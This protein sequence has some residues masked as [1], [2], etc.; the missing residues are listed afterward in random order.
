MNVQFH[1]RNGHA[2]ATVALNDL[3]QSGT[4]D[5]RAAVCFITLPGAVFLRRHAARLSQNDGFFVASIDPP[6]NLDAML[7]LHRAAPGRIYIH[8]GGTTPEE[9][10]AGRSL[11]HSKVLLAT[12]NGSCRLWV[13]SHNMTA[14]AILGGNIEAGLEVTAASDDQI[15]RDAL[16]HLETCRATAELCDPSQMERYRE[17]QSR[18]RPRPGVIKPA[19]LFVIHAHAKVRPTEAPFTVHIR[20]VPTQFDSRFQVDGGVRLF[21][22]PVGSLTVGREVDVSNAVLWNG[23]ITAL[24]RTDQHPK[25]RG[26]R[27]RFDAADFDLDLPDLRTPPTLVASG[28]SSITPLTQVVLRMDERGE[29][30]REAFSVGSQKPYENLLDSGGMVQELHEVSQEMLR[31][32]TPPS[33]DGQHLLYRPLVGVKQKLQIAGYEETMKSVDRKKWKDESTAPLL[34]TA[35]YSAQAP[36]HP[37]EAFFFKTRYVIREEPPTEPDYSGD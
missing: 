30:G 6:T 34:E 31:F 25:N 12:D 24:V 32:F 10:R 2:D 28:G 27:G 33:H 5:V 36:K 1:N 26:V 7:A 17:I 37:V 22:H 14:N 15:V 35:E 20:L 18:R 23:A 16:Q 9:V 19:N 29:P 4:V 21:L 3:L 11:M 8:L 13:G